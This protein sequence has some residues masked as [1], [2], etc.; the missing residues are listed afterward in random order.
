MNI[1][2]L[3][4]DEFDECENKWEEEI[5]LEPDCFV[6]GALAFRLGGSKTRGAFIQH[7][8]QK[9]KQ[10]KILH[11]GDQI[12]KVNGVDVRR[13]T[14][15]QIVNIL[16]V[17]VYSN[18]HALVQV[19]RQIRCK[20]D[21]TVSKDE[22]GNLRYCYPVHDNLAIDNSNTTLPVSLS[23]ITGLSQSAIYARAVTSTVHCYKDLTGIECAQLV[24]F[25]EENE[26]QFSLCKQ[27]RKFSIFGYIKQLCDNENDYEYDENCAECSKCSTKWRWHVVK[28]RWA[29]NAMK[30]LPKSASDFFG[31][32]IYQKAYYNLI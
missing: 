16:R 5:R 20:D 29:T 24:C 23:D 28:H 13:L 22:N 7:V 15:D 18:G 32:R 10:S 31:L 4:T 25:N 8:N 21:D 27:R 9:S 12:L 30:F 3:L 26:Q 11:K 2:N 19:S 1:T 6:N 14:C 17:A